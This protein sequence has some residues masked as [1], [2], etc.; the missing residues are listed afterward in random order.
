VGD[1]LGVPVI[2]LHAL[3]VVLY[4]SLD[5]CPVAGGDVSAATDGP[6]GDFFCDDHTHF[7]R[8]GAEA[9]AALVAQAVRDQGLALQDYLR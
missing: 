6:V 5:F 9:M 3:S 1:A 7:D 4:N 8:P 2:D